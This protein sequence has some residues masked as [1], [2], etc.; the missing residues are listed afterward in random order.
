M[1]YCQAAREELM[2]ARIK[3]LPVSDKGFPV[4]WFVHW[5]DGVPD[6]RVIATGKMKQAVSAERCWICGQPLG[7]YLCSVI[8]PMCAV[9]RVISEPPSHRECA[10]YAARACPFLSNPRARRNEKGLPEDSVAAA[11]IPIGR[12]PG[13]TAVWIQGSPIAMQPVDNGVLFRL[14]E[15]TEVLWFCK[16]RAARR[17]EVVESISSGLPA[18]IKEA[19]REGE[20]AV[21]ALRR[22]VQRVQAYLPKEE[23]AHELATTAGAQG[24]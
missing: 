23:E 18:L 8:G 14:A 4:P 11:G 19:E 9:N 1:T 6:F 20:E 24:A 17:D 7:R 3:A 10:V 21:R 13:V 5:A 15:P 2:P 16:G 12:N 22:Y